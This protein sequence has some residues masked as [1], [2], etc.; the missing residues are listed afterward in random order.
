MALLFLAEKPSVLSQHTHRKMDLKAFVLSDI[1]TETLLAPLR[2]VKSWNRRRLAQAA[3][4]QVPLQPTKYFS[5]ATVSWPAVG[6][7]QSST[8]MHT[9]HR[10]VRPTLTLTP[11]SA[12]RASW[13]SPITRLQSRQ[14]SH[15][16]LCSRFG[17]HG[18][19]VTWTAGEDVSAVKTLS[20]CFVVTVLKLSRWSQC[21]FYHS[22]WSKLCFIL[23]V[24]CPLLLNLQD[25]AQSCA[26]KQLCKLQSVRQRS[27]P[28][29]SAR[30]D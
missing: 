28:W 7:V 3:W 17:C 18:W 20:C 10:A 26:G 19:A 22:E 9:D 5:L 30:Q 14:N 4:P 21:L 15:R 2:P 12:T 24:L 29:M 16:L 13:L 23:P 6:S 11:P 1:T 27:Q 25:W 8:H